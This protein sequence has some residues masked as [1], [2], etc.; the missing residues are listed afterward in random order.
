MTIHIPI[1]TVKYFPNLI[2]LYTVHLLCFPTV[3]SHF[4]YNKAVL[5]SE[6]RRRE[7]RE[8]KGQGRGQGID[9]TTSGDED[10]SS[11]NTGRS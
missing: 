1:R 4:L 9:G 3:V 7:E 8:G 6:L 10:C 2:A 5:V 11:G